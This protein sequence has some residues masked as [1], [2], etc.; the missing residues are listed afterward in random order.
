MFLCNM[1]AFSQNWPNFTDVLAGKQ[2]Q[3]LATP[4]PNRSI[5]ANYLAE[6]G[7][8]P[9]DCVATALAWDRLSSSA[10]TWP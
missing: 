10:F 9:V 8:S 3:N 1:P 2:F 6:G 5:D 7:H 4:L